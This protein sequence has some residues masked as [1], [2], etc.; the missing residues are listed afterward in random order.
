VA[1]G[2]VIVTPPIT[3]DDYSFDFGLVR[4]VSLGN[5]VWYDVN[6][7]GVLDA[8]E[9]GVPGVAVE[10]YQDTDGSGGYTPGVDQLLST[11]TT[12]AGGYYTFTDLLPSRYPTETYLVVITSTN[13]TAGGVLAGYASS[14]GSV[15][16]NSDLN[17]QD[18]GAVIG[19]LGAG[20][21]VASTPV[22]LTVGG[23]PAND[24]DLDTNTNLTIDFGFFAPGRVG[25]YVWVDLN[26][27]GVQDVGEIPI[28]GVTV[29]LY[30]SAT[31]AYLASTT[32]NASGLYLFSDLP[33]DVTY[34]VQL[35]PANFTA[36]GA[37][38]PYTATLYGG[39][40]FDNT[41]SN[42]NPSALF[43]GSGYAV[44]TTLTQANP[45]DL[46]LDFGFYGG[47]IGDYV[48]A[49]VDSDG[50]Q[51]TDSGEF[52]IG[53]VLV[54]L[55]DTDTGAFI[56]ST[57]TDGSGLYLFDNLPLN[58]DY[59]VQLSRTNFLPGGALYPYV[60]TL[61]HIVGSP[62]TD[63]D[64]DAS[65]LFNGSGYAVTT[66][67][68]TAI[69]E[70]LTLD[71]GLVMPPTLGLVKQVTPAG[72]VTPGQQ[73]TYTLCYSNAGQQPATGVVITDT[74]PANTTYVPGS[75]TPSPSSGPDPLIWD[76]GTLAGGASG[77]VTFAVQISMTVQVNGLSLTYTP[78]GWVLGESEAVTPTITPTP[79]AQPPIG[80]ETPAPTPLPETETPAVTETP[81]GTIEAT[82]TSTPQPTAGQDVTPAAETETPT[83]AAPPTAEV[84]PTAVLEP[85]PSAVPTPTPSAQ[86]PIGTETAIPQPTV[87]QAE[88][89]P[90]LEVTSTVET[91]AAVSWRVPGWAAP[92]WQQAD[93]TPTVTPTPSAE[94]PVGTSSPT[95]G[96]DVT[97]ESSP[98]VEA[99]PSAQPPV[100][101]DTET[102]PASATPAG[103]TETPTPTA[104]A[105]AQPP[106]GTDTETPPASAT[107][108]G[109]TETPTPTAT[110]SAQPPIETETPTATPLTETPSAQP[111]IGT[112]TATATVDLTPV[113]TSTPVETV[114]ITPTPVVTATPV[115]TVTPVITIALP[116]GPEVVPFETY[117]VFIVNTATIGSDQTPTRA[118]T[119][120]NTL[121]SRVD[122]VVSKSVD[123]TQAHPGDVVT[124]TLSVLQNPG[125]NSNATNV[126]V[127][128][129]LP[130]YVDILS[131][132]VT[133]GAYE[134]AGRVCTWTIPVLAPSQVEHMVIRTV[135]NNNANPPPVTMRNQAT[136]H[137]DQGGP[138]T[139]NVVT[140]RVPKPPQHHDHHEENEPTATAVP[141]PAPA[142][143]PTPTPTPAVMY[144][145][146]TGGDAPLAGTAAWWVIAMALAVLA[147]ALVWRPKLGK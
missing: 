147:L 5:Q 57:V 128:D 119:V 118:S 90:T 53:G 122:P 75:A 35:S 115:I 80:T 130:I 30:D 26:R 89:T 82:P 77:C 97:P 121:I 72:T 139:S 109:E 52:G 107:P 83:L 125:S 41:D 40:P 22:S 92:L 7:N 113:L 9:A 67:L 76:I 110:A 135:V 93:E 45:Q 86:P 1:G 32:T 94:P 95:A 132:D 39:V 29:D 66:T 13:F 103:E 43:N 145:P 34:V 79:S 81:A 100:G 105:S 60:P 6:D 120:T 65:A 142:A 91:P 12:A 4:R 14:T 136:L 51:G 124:F 21:Y 23:E 84:T 106:V 8:G 50:I 17:D 20:G 98:T 137:F 48:W 102:P 64:A 108:A 49:D 47:R 28:P 126:Q 33:L 127:V 10:L 61:L 2:L 3:G 123:P 18:H 88:P 24:G 70:D 46:T 63:S 114:T 31:G 68:T 146:E 71:F 117:Q 131:V 69:T 62:A 141:S 11:T 143:T 144:L 27:D 138:R 42:A 16:G 112:V 55:Y 85:T 59:T 58:V 19:T 101:T 15:G 104:T 116:S 56:T 38:Y 111:P 73:L 36:G 87:G 25:D 99:T 74:I 44:T 37:L 140:V 96:Q 54:D 129:I 134:V 133:G 78:Q